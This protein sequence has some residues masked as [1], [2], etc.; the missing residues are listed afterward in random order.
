MS[1]KRPSTTG[2]IHLPKPS[3]AEPL[4]QHEADKKPMRFRRGERAEFQ[5]LQKRAK[6][7][8]LLVN[9]SSY[10]LYFRDDH[11]EP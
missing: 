3:C 1:A 9:R 11:A 10:E 6:K 2:S 7:A 8:G 5:R 4:A